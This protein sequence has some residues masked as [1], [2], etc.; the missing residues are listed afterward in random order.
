MTG[1]RTSSWQRWR[2]TASSRAVSGRQSAANGRA[3]PDGSIGNILYCGLALAGW[4]STTLLA[5]AGCLTVLFMMAGNGSLPGFFEQISLLGRH[6][7]AA[8]PTA[9]KAFDTE[10]LTAAVILCALTGYFRR[11]ALISIFKAGGGDGQ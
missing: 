4:V 10:L 6:Y 5:A 1:E 9:R 11:G 3:C 8:A 2:Q 7:L